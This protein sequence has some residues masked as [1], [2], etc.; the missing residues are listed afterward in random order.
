[1]VER[2]WRSSDGRLKHHRTTVL[3]VTQHST[4]HQSVNMANCQSCPRRSVLIV[5]WTALT[6]NHNNAVK[7]SAC[8]DLLDELNWR[9]DCTDGWS[10]RCSQVVHV[11]SRLAAG[12][13]HPADREYTAVNTT[14]ILHST[15]HQTFY[16]GHPGSAEWSTEQVT[17]RWYAFCIN[18][19]HHV[20]VNQQQLLSLSRCIWTLLFSV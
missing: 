3:L 8:P 10:Q 4:V 17:A 2:C 7:S 5:R 16:R 15:A 1:M 19:S 11:F 13:S 12:C 6:A 9:T 18:C 20:I 14:S